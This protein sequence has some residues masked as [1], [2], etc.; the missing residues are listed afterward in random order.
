MRLLFLLFWLSGFIAV[1]SSQNCYIPMNPYVV[2]ITPAA[3][4]VNWDAMPNATAYEVN[5]RPMNA[6]STI[7]WTTVSVNTNSVHLSGL[8]PNTL[9]RAQIRSV[10]GQ[11]FSDF[12]P[13]IDFST[14]TCAPP[15]G[16]SAAN[17]TD[18]TTDVIW[19]I[20]QG[21]SGYRLLYRV[22]ETNPGSWN[23]VFVSGTFH[24]LTGLTPSTLYE[25]RLLS[26][27][28]GS[29]SDT[30]KAVYFS[31]IPCSVPSN[32]LITSQTASSISLEWDAVPNATQY[33]IRY[34]LVGN[35][36]WS[37]VNS[38][39]HARVVS[40]LAGNSLY[41]FQVRSRCGSQEFSAYTL[42]ISGFTLP[43]AM[44][45]NVIISNVTVNS[46]TLG[47]NNAIG[48]NQ[49]RLEYKKEIDP[50]WTTVNANN[51]SKT[52]NNL[53]P[54][55]D[56]QVRV[57]SRCSGNQHSA[58]SE[59]LK[60]RTKG[61]V[62]PDAFY[63]SELGFTSMKLE[64]SPVL[65]ATRY[66]L[67]YRL[68]NDT[69]WTN[70]NVNDT[71]RVFNNLVPY[72]T[73]EFR[74]RSQC[75]NNIYSEYSESMIGGLMPCIIPSGF[76]NDT[77]TFT[78]ATFGWD[79]LS[80]AQRFRLEYKQEQDIAWTERFTQNNLLTIQN[81]T[82]DQ[83]YHARL[84]A[85]CGGNS[86]SPVGDTIVF[87]TTKCEAPFYLAVD[88]VGYDRLWVSWDSA[89]VNN[90]R[91]EYQADGDSNWQIINTQS[92]QRVIN[93]LAPGTNYNVRLSH[94]CQ[95]GVFSGYSNTLRLLTKTCYGPVK[96]QLD[97]ISPI[98]LR[99]YWS[100]WEGPRRFSVKYKKPS[101]TTWTIRNV[102]DTTLTL[103]IPVDSSY[104]FQIHQKCTNDI[105]AFA[106]AP[107]PLSSHNCIEYAQYVDCR[108]IY[109]RFRGN[110]ISTVRGTFNDTRI[111]IRRRSGDNQ[112]YE[113]D[114]T[115]I[116]RSQIGFGGPDDLNNVHI[117][118]DQ[119]PSLFPFQYLCD[120]H[121]EEIFRFDIIV[122]S[123]NQPPW[124]DQEVCVYP[125]EF[126]CPC[127]PNIDPHNVC[128]YHV[129]MYFQDCSTLVIELDKALPDELP[130]L[131]TFETNSVFIGEFNLRNIGYFING[132]RTRA[133]V[134][135]ALFGFPPPICP[136]NNFLS[137]TFTYNFREIV[138]KESIV[139]LCPQVEARANKTAT[140]E[141][142]NVTLTAIP[143]GLGM[144]DYDY[145]WMPGNL[146]GSRISVNPS[147]TTTYTLTAFDHS[148]GCTATS[149]VTVT[150]TPIPKITSTCNN[151][152]VCVGGGIADFTF[153]WQS[154]GTIYPVE[155][156]AP[157][158]AGAF[159]FMQGNYTRIVRAQPTQPGTFVIGVRIGWAP[160]QRIQLCTL[161]VN[162][163]TP[164]MFIAPLGCIEVGGTL[165]GL[166][167]LPIVPFTPPGI[168][169]I[170]PP[171]FPFRY[172][173]RRGNAQ[174]PVIQTVNNINHNNPVL[175][176]NIPDITENTTFT[177]TLTNRF[178]CTSTAQVT[179]T[180]CCNITETLIPQKCYPTR[181]RVCVPAQPNSEGEAPAVYSWSLGNTPIGQTD[182]NCFD[183][184]VPLSQINNPVVHVVVT[185]T[186]PTGTIELY[187]CSKALNHLFNGTIPAYE[188]TETTSEALLTRLRNEGLIPNETNII[189]PLNP[190]INTSGQL[191]RVW[192]FPRNFTI[193]SRFPIAFRN[194]RMVMSPNVAL[195][196]QTNAE[197]TV[198]SSYI[199]GALDANGQPQQWAGITVGTNSDPRNAGRL[200]FDNVTLEHAGIGLNAGNGTVNQP[201][202]GVIWVDNSCLNENNVHI[203]IANNTAGWGQ[204]NEI[205]P[206]RYT[207]ISGTNLL[208]SSGYQYRSPLI[209]RNSIL[210]CI[211]PLPGSSNLYTQ[212]GID[213]QNM[214]SAQV[215][216]SINQNANLFRLF[217]QV[218]PFPING[219]FANPLDPMP[220]NLIERASIGIR[221]QMNNLP[222]GNNPLSANNNSPLRML[223]VDNNN[224]ANLIPRSG[225]NAD[226][227]VGIDIL[228]NSTRP[229]L[230]IQKDARALKV[231]SMIGV[232]FRTQ[233]NYQL[234]IPTT[235]IVT[236]TPSNTF[237]QD[238][239]LSP[240]N[241]LQSSSRMDYG[242]RIAQN[243]GDLTVQNNLFDNIKGT[244]QAY[245]LCGI[246]VSEPQNIA[247][248]ISNNR[249]QDIEYGVFVREFT[250][251][252]TDNNTSI[253]RN[254]F[255]SY[256]NGAT[257]F[258]SSV[259]P[260]P[261]N[262]GPNSNLR[263]RGVISIKEN[264]FEEYVNNRPHNIHN[265]LLDI[266][267]YNIPRRLDGA[268]NVL[269]RMRPAS[270]QPDR[271]GN[272]N[273]NGFVDQPPLTIDGNRFYGEQ[274]IAIYVL[275]ENGTAA[276]RSVVSNNIINPNF[277]TPPEIK[278]CK[279]GIHSAV[280]TYVDL[281]NN[282]VDLGN[283]DPR[284]YINREPGNYGVAFTGGHDDAGKYSSAFW[285][286][287]SHVY[288]MN[289]NR[290]QN[291]GWGIDVQGDN[292]PQVNLRNN[293]MQRL[294]VGLMLR[295][296]AGAPGVV[297]RQGQL[298]P[299]LSSNN[300]G[301]DININPQTFTINSDGSNS[302]FVVSTRPFMNFAANPIAND[303]LWGVNV[304]FNSDMGEVDYQHL[305]QCRPTDP[306]DFLTYQLQHLS[307][308]TYPTEE[309]M[310]RGDLDGGDADM[311][312]AFH[313]KL[314]TLLSEWGNRMTDH[315]PV[316]DSFYRAN[317]HSAMAGFITVE[318]L[319]DL[320]PELARR[321]N[322]ELT[323]TCIQERNQQ[324][325]YNL[326]L[327]WAENDRK[328]TEVQKA[329]LARLAEQCPHTGGKAVWQARMMRFHMDLYH[330]SY[331]NDCTPKQTQPVV[332]PKRPA[333]NML[334]MYPNPASTSVSL[335]YDLT[336]EA[337]KV[338]YYNITGVVIA[339]Q[340]AQGKKGTITTETSKW[341]SGVYTCKIVNRQGAT[342]GV[343]KLVIVK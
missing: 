336:D 236:G 154:D 3:A 71:F 233:G 308:K 327:D 26:D 53:D 139:L 52:I 258:N 123:N 208:I 268:I 289:C 259:S 163:Q 136:N 4:T 104:Q 34:R 217:N 17:P 343:S 293:L 121:S 166:S 178:G 25:T 243:A 261:H 50:N 221:S 251:I 76:R 203:R 15:A 300:N 86:Y 63:V 307:L 92:T 118:L 133:F 291:G 220:K 173:L 66:Q 179:V 272:E 36:T 81:L 134:D 175:L 18:N 212:I 90:Y 325:F 329:D 292:I 99:L 23:V 297:G 205:S 320:K 318:R 295:L 192:I 267:P 119:N 284:N 193:N 304:A 6:P 275:S 165:T 59:V 132:E 335:D 102:N 56:Y 330:Y 303:N 338:I 301:W 211:D 279:I 286:S 188:V 21:A 89:A 234:H 196:V 235:G 96:V 13:Y 324:T 257:F 231:T 176:T 19:N 61:C 31:T 40:G 172:E 47:W 183:F 149:T 216:C 116:V 302:L 10:C 138:C 298:T 266:N 305:D 44:P 322:N 328:L 159:F 198:T 262:P 74:I 237:T 28:G 30:S 174:G 82:P 143:T 105:S 306:T 51:T 206:G 224:I 67:S 253:D 342:L 339:E 120:D 294:N 161:T 256:K 94:R 168:P 228:S 62:M 7:A 277:R 156:I 125:V 170:N 29:L 93:N 152:T 263:V 312:Y 148:T 194:V 60:F 230:E 171:Q 72:E 39:T 9:Y 315:S 64:W 276:A 299:A 107:Q 341:A 87:R 73:Y 43:C 158:G 274:Q 83:T 162:P 332:K 46:V 245:A 69:A 219:W 311:R 314:M 79:S 35:N 146:S 204:W 238:R 88:S 110:P 223:Y 252:A 80:V 278:T 254:S 106:L 200:F 244:T 33:N 288:E 117:I 141:N 48:S 24:Q 58:Y 213:I 337:D 38:N 240:T 177:V 323:P 333:L 85:H 144:H 126:E 241:E 147:T 255:F 209:L 264:L 271:D 319:L 150:V 186:S 287:Q 285:L 167:A 70:H 225:F 182:E 197:L 340:S 202:S 214:N 164:V 222:L 157:P 169:D 127:I 199:H 151:Q 75:A 309:Q 310:A 137:M 210:T 140:C 331:P 27:C 239:F 20:A 129:Y 111:I 109:I 201:L 187:R 135:L 95:T 84:S 218:P 49:Y 184:D 14:E 334:S 273:W 260:N 326:Y 103:N 98:Q 37:N 145:V 290:M 321:Y 124:D 215:G 181:T 32:L 227:S 41:E 316:L 246:H 185:R 269:G 153:S 114:I 130:A 195:T 283:E 55:T 317:A 180:I 131:L 78:S 249:F 115:G 296:T 100:I 207:F 1:S 229:T 265:P 2:G 242:I 248:N 247:S 65:N 160:C 232:L 270:P 42:I 190:A 189:D 54:D 191:S 226:V 142:E 313:Q 122:I 8:N 282:F 68:Y 5:Y 128:D 12:S 97:T 22:A 11:D 280:S 250:N 91:L 155:L 112:G 57:R 281:I 16:I 113:T 45:E 108:E 101:D 77:V